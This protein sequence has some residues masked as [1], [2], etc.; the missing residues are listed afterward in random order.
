M[1][2]MGENGKITVFHAFPVK[3]NSSSSWSLLKI[4]KNIRLNK[5]RIY[6]E[7]IFRCGFL[8][9]KM[10]AREKYIYFPDA[11]NGKSETNLTIMERHYNLRNYHNTRNSVYKYNFFKC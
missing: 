8:R 5:D 10:C 2:H 9:C 4:I 7:L 3:E 6:P 11:E 1:L